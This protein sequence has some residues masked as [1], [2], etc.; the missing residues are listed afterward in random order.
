MIS[1]FWLALLE[2]IYMPIYNF[3]GEY[4]SILT[5]IILLLFF[6]LQIWIF[7]HLFLKPFVFLLK[8]FVNFIS[9]NSLWQ[10]VEVDEKK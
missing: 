10:E 4:S 3:Y 6:T 2:A 8:I 5:F 7:W 1:D 9:K